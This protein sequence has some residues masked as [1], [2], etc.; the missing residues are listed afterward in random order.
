ML[1]LAKLRLTGSKGPKSA[2]EG[3]SQLA[4]HL[5][6]RLGWLHRGIHQNMLPPKSII[7]YSIMIF[8]ESMKMK[9]SHVRI[10][11][12]IKFRDMGHGSED[13]LEPLSQE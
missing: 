11:T 5:D 10:G 13:Q 8:P 6:I 2:G 1:Q 4:S 12:K 3:S 7:G 9:N